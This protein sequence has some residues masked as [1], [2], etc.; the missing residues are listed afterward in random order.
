MKDGKKLTGTFSS[1]HPV[2]ALLIG[3]YMLDRYTTGNVKRISPEAPVPV[4][5]IENEESRP[6]GA[7]NVVLNL[8]SLGTKVIAVGRIGDDNA[9]KELI[10]N[11]NENGADVNYLYTQEEYCT[12][13]K[14]R[15]IAG[16][17]QLL[18]VDREK[19]IPI[20]EE[21]EIK[22]LH[23]LPIIMDQVQVVAIS[24]YGKG[25]L[26]NKVLKSVI[27]KARSKNIPVIVDPKGINFSKYKNA[28]I[29]KPNLQEAYS[30]ANLTQSSPM[31]EVA[32]VLVKQT[33]VEKL[34]ITRSEAG[35]TIFD[36]KVNR[37]D[38]PA[39]I[40]EVK[41]VTGAGDTVLATIS[42]AI[43]NGLDI[44]HAAQLAN[45]SAGIAIEH[46]GCARV[47]LSNIA[48]RLL[49]FDGD[50]KIFEERHLYALK[51]VLNGRKICVL[52]V[53]SCNGM[54]TLLFQSIRKLAIRE[55]HCLIV[56][57]KD[58]EPNQEFISLMSSLK[59]VDFIILQSENLKNLCE[60]I[61]PDE[62]FEIQDDKMVSLDH[63]KALLQSLS[64]KKI[65]SNS[66]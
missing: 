24:D 7:G 55:S 48:H 16:S 62:V 38:F 40:K 10:T 59:E 42:I 11:L 22:L 64:N 9:G 41:D 1:F 52:G 20:S 49:Q 45:I 30:A 44:C 66:I 58:H 56:Y 18:R 14:N 5:I 47:S 51:M 39:H 34:I 31:E 32:K 12:P 35:I 17:Q 25:F 43:A 33:N 60:S 26:S 6:G 15:L 21:L 63:A 3:D 29:I 13:I 57:I 27:N 36:D 23:D 37:R 61:N 8:I 46:I 50:S 53:D 28:T 19:N 2:K 4:I 54:T 65:V